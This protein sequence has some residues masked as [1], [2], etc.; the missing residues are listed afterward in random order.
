MLTQLFNEHESFEVI[1]EA[2]SGPE[3]VDL[4]VKKQADLI[5]IDYSLPGFDGA[6]ALRLIGL[7][8]PHQ[9]AIGFTS[10]D[11]PE[12]IESFKDNGATQVILKGS[13]PELLI[14]LCLKV[15]GDTTM[16]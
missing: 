10:F 6:E 13:D 2:S 16:A 11:M 4:S 12:I 9:K 7:N 15:L 8:N 14:K 3:A 1:G 5:L